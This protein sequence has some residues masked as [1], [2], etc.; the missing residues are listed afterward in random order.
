LGAQ[1]QSLVELTEKRNHSVQEVYDS[2]AKLED[3]YT[4]H[5][6]RRNLFVKIYAH[7]TKGIEDMISTQQI[8]HGPWLT[9]LI[10]SFSEEYRKAVWGYESHRSDI[11]PLPWIFD[12]DQARQQKIGRATQLLLSLDAHIL[13]DLPNTI[14][15][16]ARSVNELLSYKK[17]YFKL[18]QMFKSLIPQLFLILYKEAKY[19]TDLG[20]HP[21]EIIKRHVV[22]HIVLLMRKTAWDRALALTEAKTEEARLSYLR[23]MDLKTKKLSVLIT[24]LD[25]LFSTKPGELLPTKLRQDTWRSLKM[26]GEALNDRVSQVKWEHKYQGEVSRFDLNRT[27][28]PQ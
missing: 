16:S 10:V 27:R 22:N 2:F 14:S 23:E 28:N 12:F 21:S 20:Q 7:I 17:D 25:P 26:I 11:V 24:S 18:N 3:Y 4:L 6:D 15:Q 19:P 8:Y 13:Y 5:G 1:A 9:D